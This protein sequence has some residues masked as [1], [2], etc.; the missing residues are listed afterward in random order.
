MYPEQIKMLRQTYGLTREEFAKA[1]GVSAQT[2]YFW[3]NGTHAPS[4]YDSVV[5]YRLWEMSFS[6]ATREEARQALRKA[7]DLPNSPPFQKH[8]DS[9]DVLGAAIV[10]GLIGFGLGVL[11]TALFGKDDGENKNA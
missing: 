5:L 4:R 10:G 9:S 1:L 6:P 7:I 3:E 11:L 8:T 2:I